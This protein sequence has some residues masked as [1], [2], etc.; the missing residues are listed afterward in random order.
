VAR[1]DRSGCARNAHREAG[2]L[3][4]AGFNNTIGVL[5]VA[6]NGMLHYQAKHAHERASS[7]PAEA[8]VTAQ[9]NR[10]EASVLAAAVKDYAIFLLDREGVVATWNTGARA[11]KQY[12]SQEIVGQHFSRFYTPEDQAADLPARLLATAARDGHVESEGW[13]VRKDGSRFWADVVISALRDEHGELAGFAKVTRDLTERKRAEDALERSEQDLSATLYSI[14]DGVIATDLDGRVTRMN[15]IAERLTGWTQDEAAGQPIESVFRIFNE[16]TRSHVQNPVWRVLKEGIVVGL[17]NHTV[18]VSRD[19]TEHPVADSGAPIRDR[20]GATRGVVLV[21]RDVTEE[22]RVAEALRQSEESLFA[23]LY[24]IGDGVIA[25]DGRGLVTRLNPV[26]EK[27]TGWA[28]KEA[29]GHPIE[30]VFDIIN[31]ETRARAKN[32]VHRVLAEGVISGLANHTALISRDGVE[33]P[34]A[35]SGAPIHDLSGKTRGAVLV[36]R[37]IT[38]ERKAEEAIRL[39]EE[40]LRLMIASVKDYAIFMLDPRG[41]VLNWSPGAEGIKGYR[42]DEIIGQSFARFYPAADVEAGK[43]ARELEA[44]AAIGRF[45]DEGWR[46][47]KDGSQF[48]ASVTISAVR[49]EHGTLHGFTKVTRDLTDRRQAEQ[50]TFR[51]ATRQAALA[52]LGLF[53]L[54]VRELP[55]LFEQALSVVVETL[56]TELCH[57]CELDSDGQRLIPRASRGG[58]QLASAPGRIPPGSLAELALNAWLPV[59]IEDAAA[60][61]RFPIPSELLEQGVLSGMTVALPVA[62]SVMP[63]GLL[64]A[65]SAKRISFSSDDAG[66]LQSVALLIATAVSRN[67]IEDRL[68]LSEQAAAE[69][70]LKASQAKEA[71]HQREVF[72]SVAAHELR[73]PVS[74][75]LLKLQGLARLLGR[76]SAQPSVGHRVQDALRQ[77]NRLVSLIESLLDLS[78]IQAGRLEVRPAPFDLEMLVRGVVSDY[79][80]RAAETGTEIRLRSEGDTRGEWDRERLEQVVVN[81]LSNAMRYGAGRPVNIELSGQPDAVR[82]TVAD[83]GIGIQAEDLQ[84]I[85]DPF[86]RVAPVKHFAGLGLGLYIARRL[87]EAHGGK[88]EVV[89]RPAQGASFIVTLPRPSPRPAGAPQ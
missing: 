45:E 23:T 86:E 67:R 6:R 16:M 77:T 72:L 62:D 73:T 48:W 70:R 7:I 85:F 58:K 32:P 40:R 43:P 8:L 46:V 63:Y 64:S 18:V 65:Y 12:E 13:R 29:V 47:R 33:R 10:I 21:F 42:P 50:D 5:F 87:V 53:A 4:D 1:S 28:E 83:Q 71:V 79:S 41:H 55:Q 60:E 68:R 9:L 26:A 36:F 74:A 39:S 80:E 49:D 59:I 15:P 78:R 38:E 37:D 54:R 81:L 3:R 31:E 17:A 11:I 2:I 61:T 34:I 20:S 27:L 19:G 52:D 14:G 25:T 22:R 51:R 56:G 75:L 35:D 69:E 76:E 84:R 24:S 88:I 82:L 44:A 30:T 57:I 66:F 89:S